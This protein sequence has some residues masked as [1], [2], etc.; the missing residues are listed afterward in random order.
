MSRTLEPFRNP[1]AGPGK[2]PRLPERFLRW[3]EVLR[4]RVRSIPCF[5]YID[6]SPEGVIAGQQGDLVYDRVG[7]VYYQ[8]TTNTGNTGWTLF[9]GGGAW[10]LISTT[11]IT[12]VGS[13]DLTWDEAV[14]SAIRFVIEDLQID[15]DA[16][17]LECRLGHTN[18][19]TIVA[20]ADYNGIF[21]AGTTTWTNMG[22]ASTQLR[23]TSGGT[24]GNAAGEYYSGVIDVLN[25]ASANLGATVEHNGLYHNSAG[26]QLPNKLFSRLINQT[27]AMDTLRLF[28]AA[29]SFR[30]AG[31]IAMYGLT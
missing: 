25:F 4:A 13:L 23:L 19:A 6:G 2:E 1:P 3:L 12:A 27:V 20:S 28:P 30:A 21:N 31:S 8:K 10:S 14:Y 5:T 9:G 17:H 24:M 7:L 16:T 29:G 11:A 15:T 22:A 18:G 26:A